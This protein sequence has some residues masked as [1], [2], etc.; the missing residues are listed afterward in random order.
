[1]SIIDTSGGRAGKARTIHE[2]AA[3]N[4]KPV[5]NVTVERFDERGGG[6]LS[7]WQPPNP[8]RRYVIGV[9]VAEGLDHGDYSVAQVLDC[10][11]GDQVA[12]WK[13][14]LPAKEFGFEVGRLGFWY[15]TALIGV[16]ANNHGG[17]T[18]DALVEIN[19]PRLYR[20][21]TINEISQRY[22]IKWGWLTNS[23]TRPLMIDDLDQALRDG[24]I[25]IHCKQTLSELRT[26]IRNEKG[27]LEGSPHDDEVMSLA[28]AVQMLEYNASPGDEWDDKDNYWT[29]EWWAEQAKV[30][31]QPKDLPIGYHNRRNAL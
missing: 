13:G 15:Q 24:A 6:P 21:R 16:E 30:A 10:H 11:T 20:R 12:K 27:K 9:D 18:I 3:P 25:T 31:A 22:T 1:M 28:I 19:Y 23:S 26:F 5:R 8:N 7:V 17:S 29:I 4:L 2:V 14:H